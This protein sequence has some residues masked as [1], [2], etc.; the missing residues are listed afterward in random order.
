MMGEKLFPT[1]ANFQ[2]KL[3]EKITGMMLEMENSE[4]LTFLASE[5]RLRSNIDRA[6]EILG[7]AKDAPL[8]TCTTD[9]DAASMG[10]ALHT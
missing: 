5:Q 4:L 6:L 3:A 10:T 1:I 2:P 8:D 7:S 9:A